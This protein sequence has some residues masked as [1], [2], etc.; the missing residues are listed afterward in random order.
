MFEEHSEAGGVCNKGGFGTRRNQPENATIACRESVKA[1]LKLAP[2]MTDAAL[3]NLTLEQW[4]RLQ[5]EVDA[6]TENERRLVFHDA[7]EGRLRQQM[8]D[9]LAVHSLNRKAN[10]AADPPDFQFVGCLDSCEESLRRHLEEVA[11]H[12]QTFGAP[13]FFDIAMAYRR[14]GDSEYLPNCPSHVKPRHFVEETAGY[15][16]DG[17]LRPV[18]KA[19]AN[20][21]QLCWKENAE[22]NQVCGYSMEEMAYTVEILLRD[23]GLTNGFARTVFVVGHGSSGRRQPYSAAHNCSFC[24]GHSGGPNARIFATMANHPRVR[25]LLADN[26]LCIPDGTVFVGAEHQT[27]SDTIEYYDLSHVAPGQRRELEEAI[28]VIEKALERN[29]HERCRRFESADP[30]MSVENA[31]WHVVDRLCDETESHPEY[32]FAGNALCFVGRRWRTRGLFLDRRSFL[33]SYDPTTDDEDNTS[34]ARLLKLVLPSCLSVNLDYFFSRTDPEVFGAGSQIS[35][36]VVGGLGVISENGGD[37]RTGLPLEMVDFHEPVRL[38]CVVETTPAALLR[39]LDQ[40]PR[41]NRL[42]ANCW[43]HLATLDPD[44]AEIHVLRKGFFER[45]HPECSSLPNVSSSRDWRR[46]RSGNLPIATI[47]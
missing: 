16:A 43:F 46:N 30:S 27:C 31:A 33:A 36:N 38:L 11:P 42:A 39:V 45:H 37:L 9:A 17:T 44:S 22:S 23:I 24:G 4:Q 2:G 14:L 18:W 8:L 29:A 40:I 19:S 47:S 35:H 1:I 15:Q 41:V 3:D 12:C 13:G 28:S 5:L 26:G 21:A 20:P 6:F 7:F 34:L 32:S 10:P 25:R